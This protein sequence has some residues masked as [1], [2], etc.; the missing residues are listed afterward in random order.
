MEIINKF[1]IT[2]ANTVERPKYMEAD[3]LA[4]YSAAKKY[5]K[6]KNVLDIGCGF[7]LGTNLIAENGALRVD[8]IDYS[9]GAILGA[10]KSKLKNTSFEVVDATKIRNIKKKYDV[11]LA[12]EIIEHL[13]V[14]LASKFVEDIRFLLKENGFLILSTP[15]GLHTK[16]FLGKP[17]NPYHVKEYKI[18]ELKPMFKNF[19][20]VSLFGIRCVN[21]PFLA[22]QKEIEKTLNYR[23]AF[24]VGHFIFIKSMLSYIPRDLKRNFTKEDVLPSMKVADYKIDKDILK[25][26]GLYVIA[27]K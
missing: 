15:N 26:E 24:I 16:F 23:I 13:P 18:E 8:G 21:K 6:G 17:H 2:S 1:K 25:S 10:S 27:S 5:C 12:F 9:E 11:I 19:K 14:E 20:N 3:V 4:R 7:G 22:K